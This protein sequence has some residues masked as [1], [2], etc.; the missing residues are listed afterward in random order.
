MGEMGNRVML[1]LVF[2]GLSLMGGCSAIQDYIGSGPLGE[3]GP[4]VY[5]GFRT[6]LSSKGVTAKTYYLCLANP[7]TSNL[8]GVLKSADPASCGIIAAIV[9]A[10]AAA[11][12]AGSTVLDT[13]LLP[14]TLSR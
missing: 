11:D 6:F 5:G 10:P 14:F 12:L 2:A 1:P 4:H 13:L 9:V 7:S 3:E 8:V